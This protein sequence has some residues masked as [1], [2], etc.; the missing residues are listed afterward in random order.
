MANKH[1]GEVTLDLA[2]KDYVLAPTF[3]VVAE[4]E[5]EMG[6][7]LFEIGRKLELADITARDLVKLA[8]TALKAGGHEVAEGMIVQAISDDGAYT[9]IAVF[10]QFVRNYAFGGR[11]EKK[12]AA[13]APKEPEP[14][15]ETISES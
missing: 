2:G 14:S 4:I 7:N 9:V 3:G 15:P 1:R 6:T 13:D 11:E 5:D 12:A 10:V 8:G